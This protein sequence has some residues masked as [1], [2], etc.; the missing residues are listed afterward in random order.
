MS[1]EINENESENI[2]VPC[3]VNGGILSVSKK[4]TPDIEQIHHLLNQYAYLF[5]FNGGKWNVSL[6]TNII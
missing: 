2:I 3:P 6:L 5:S 4:S 1:E